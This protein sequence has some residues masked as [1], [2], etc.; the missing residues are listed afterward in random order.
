MCLQFETK[1]FQDEHVKKIKTLPLATDAKM[2]N[3]DAY[4]QACFFRKYNPCSNSR[5]ITFTI[6]FASMVQVSTGMKDF[7]L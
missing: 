7:G 1:R 6:F 3:R 2:K 5:L 4:E